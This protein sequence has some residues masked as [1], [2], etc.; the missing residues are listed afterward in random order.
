MQPKPGSPTELQ[1]LKRSTVHPSPFHVPI[2]VVYSELTQ[3]LRMSGAQEVHLQHSHTSL[4]LTSSH[5]ARCLQPLGLRCRKKTKER[6]A[7]HRPIP[8]LP[9]KKHNV[10]AL[11]HVVRKADSWGWT[12]GGW[13]LVKLEISRSGTNTSPGQTA[14]FSQG[15]RSFLYPRAGLTL[16]IHDGKELVGRLW[17]APCRI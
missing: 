3:V 7:V 1:G 12:G 16:A 2:F 14:Q 10:T 11:V 17:C 8:N 13:S 4:L 5:L 9:C 15:L 6:G